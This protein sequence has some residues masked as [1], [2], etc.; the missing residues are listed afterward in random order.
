M[1]NKFGF[2]F[3][4]T[5]PFSLMYTV[6]VWSFY[7]TSHCAVGVFRI[8]L[9]WIAFWFPLNSAQLRPVCNLAQWCNSLLTHMFARVFWLVY[10]P[11]GSSMRRIW[12]LLCCTCNQWG[13]VLACF[14]IHPSNETRCHVFFT[15]LEVTDTSTFVERVSMCADGLL[16]NFY[17]SPSTECSVMIVLL[18]H[19]RRMG[20]DVHLLFMSIK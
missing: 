7:L 8:F 10:Y 13:T 3:Y 18:A 11:S 12:V 2:I 6:D 16:T 15:W 4:Q 17:D 1:L 5:F 14:C 9:D 19:P 20:C